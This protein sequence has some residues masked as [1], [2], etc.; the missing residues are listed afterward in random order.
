MDTAVADAVELATI[1]VTDLV[2]S[3]RLA[4][5]VGPARADELRDEHFAVSAGGDRRVGRSRVQGHR[6]RPDGRLQLRVGGGAV[7]GVDAAPHRAPLSARRAEAAGA[8]RPR[9]GR[10][11]DQGRELLRDAV[12]RG[13]APLR[14]GRACRH[15]GLTRRANARHPA[16][17]HPFRVRRRARAEG[18]PRAGRGI[19]RPVD[20]ARGRG[21][22]RRRLAVARIDALGAAS[23]IRR[24]GHGTRKSSSEHGT[25]RAQARARWC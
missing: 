20:S 23:R 3:T 21:R 17:R 6:R 15:P 22:R 18:V 25:R 4:T 11:D 13:C 24:P 9:R 2:G 7:C 8:Y 16:R 12:D 19:R 1:L 5:S 10:V 14:P